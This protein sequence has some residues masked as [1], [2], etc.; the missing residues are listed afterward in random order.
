MSALDILP[1][2]SRASSFDEMRDSYYR[3]AKT[4][5]TEYQILFNERRWPIE[6]IE[7]YVYHPIHWRD[8]TTHGVRYWA[9]EQLDRGTWYVHRKGTPSPDRCGIDI[10]AGSK[11]AGIFCGLLIAGIGDTKGS[12]SALKRMIRSDS[13]N[14]DDSRWSDEERKLLDE[15][16]AKSIDK[17]KLRLERYPSSRSTPLYLCERRLSAPHIPAPFKNEPLRIAA[18]RWRCSQDA[19]VFS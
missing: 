9:D 12:S 18:Q 2:F 4:L 13:N 14:F 16:N 7:L 15:V 10:T 8:C 1:D 17:G 19:I 5:I 6:A 3:A 11:E